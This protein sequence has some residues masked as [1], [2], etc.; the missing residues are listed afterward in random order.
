MTS[1]KGADF[2][3]LVRSV[4]QRCVLAV[5]MIA[6]MIGMEGRAA[7]QSIEN[8]ENEALQKDAL[9]VPP[10]SPDAK[11]DEI[12]AE[13]VKQNELRTVRLQEYSAVRTYSVTDLTGKVHARE[14][15]RMEYIAPDKKTFETTSEEGS[16]LVRHLV[17]DRLI[18]SE[19][20][21]AIGKEHH[22]SSITPANYTFHLLGQEDVGT[23]HC[24]VV[25]ATPRREDKYLF[26]GKVWIDSREFAIVRITGH[27]A[28][29]LSFWITRADFVRQY[30]KF[31]DF[32]LSVKDETFVNVKLY[33]KK[34][35]TID[36]CIDT[37]N[38]VKSAALVR[39]VRSG[40]GDSG[41]P[42]S[43]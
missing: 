8:G 20:A 9:P 5:L 27:P 36:H 23:H 39:Q 29:K 12:F 22:D 28:K 31:G 33:G 10:A 18:E 25:E 26:E 1:Q 6:G 4:T 43:E 14:I 21:T 35:L 34:I 32:W 19:T 7:G 38:G 2:A 15:V 30:E 41:K 16:R 13:L 11:A 17:L 3:V 42:K 40:I 24:Y 37:V